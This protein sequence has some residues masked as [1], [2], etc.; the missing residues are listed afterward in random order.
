MFNLPIEV[1]LG[2][3]LCLDSFTRQLSRSI[4]SHFLCELQ[5]H[6]LT[7]R[8]SDA[9][10]DLAFERQKYSTLDAEMNDLKAQTDQNQFDAAAHLEAYLRKQLDN[11][12]DLTGQELARIRV[13]KIFCCINNFLNAIRQ[14]VR[15]DNGYS[16][17]I[18][19]R[20]YPI[21]YQKMTSQNSDRKAISLAQLSTIS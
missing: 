11:F 8:L 1:Y 12:T 5:V 20:S 18:N 16:D 15:N 9:E 19:F 2:H 4:R 10:R 3:Q 17:F 14:P 13:S 21:K 6:N 7:E